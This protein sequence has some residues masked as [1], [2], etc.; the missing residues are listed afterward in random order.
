MT[1]EVDPEGNETLA[2]FA[3]ADF[4]DKRILEIG[5]GFGRLTWQIA[6]KARQVTAIEPFRP[7]F[8]RAISATP[9]EL[10]ARVSF[11]NLDIEQF[12]Q[13]TPAASFDIVLLSWSL[14]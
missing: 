2:L 9:Q 12:A 14:C 5:S 4:T 10:R 3:I 8:D 6:P 1:V 11:L 13:A 7:H